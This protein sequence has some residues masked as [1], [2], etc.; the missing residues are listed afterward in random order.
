MT[1]RY[2]RL[3]LAAAYQDAK[4]GSAL[5]A[6]N[7]RSSDTTFVSSSTQLRSGRRRL[8][9]FEG[10]WRNSM[11][12]VSGLDNRSAKLGLIPASRS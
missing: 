5:P 12:A 1:E 7:L 10:G 4:R 6:F 2:M 3:P 11:S 8:F 9:V